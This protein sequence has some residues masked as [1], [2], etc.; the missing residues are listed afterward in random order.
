[1][2]KSRWDKGFTVGLFYGALDIRREF[3]NFINFYLE[4][5]T[6]QKWLN[7][8][9]EIYDKMEMTNTEELTF[10]DWLNTLPEE[11]QFKY[12][13]DTEKIEEIYAS[14]WKERRIAEYGDWGS[15]LDEIYHKR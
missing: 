11:S 13:K 14:L 12:K 10:D 5:N 3:K 15:Q 1:M 9:Q 2:F 8:K 7:E 4:W 6:Y